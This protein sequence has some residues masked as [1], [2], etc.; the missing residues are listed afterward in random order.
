MIFLRIKYSLILSILTGLLVPMQFLIA[1]PTQGFLYAAL[2]GD[3]KKTEKE[4][5]FRDL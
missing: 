2:R 5:T 1:D 3:L 4:L